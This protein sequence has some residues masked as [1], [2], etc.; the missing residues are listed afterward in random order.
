MADGYGLRPIKAQ[1]QASTLRFR[2]IA[3]KNGMPGP[4][5]SDGV[6]GEARVVLRPL[7]LLLWSLPALALDATTRLGKTWFALLLAVTASAIPAPGQSKQVQ[8]VR[9][10]VVTEEHLR[11]FRLPWPPA[12]VV[13]RKVI[14]DNQGFLWLGAADGLRRYDG[15]SFMRVPDDED[16]NGVGLINAESLMK[17]RTGA[18]WFGID[19]FLARYDPANGHLRRYRT[20]GG[21]SCD[22]GCDAHQITEDREGFVWLATNNGLIRL[23]PGTSRRTYYRHRPDD[24]ATIASD[25]VICTI[26]ARDGLLWVASSGALDAFDRHTGKVTRRIRFE[27]ESTGHLSLRG[28]PA[29]L[30]QDRSGMLWA[31]LSSGGD[32]VSID[33]N[34]EKITVYSFRVP[35]SKATTPAFVVSIAEDRTGAL[36][37][38]T[39]GLGL[40]KL[41]R[42]RDRVVWYESNPE[43]PNS[44]SADLVVGLFQDREGSFW[45]HTKGG[46]VLRF[47][48][49]PPVFRSYRHAPGNKNS[50]IDSAVISAYEDSK[51]ILWI[52]TERGLN[53]VDRRTGQ[54]KRYD[55]VEFTPGVRSIAEDRGGSL[56]FGTRGNGLVRFDRRTGAVRTFRHR[57]DDSRSLSNDYVAGLLVDRQ[58]IL[59]AAT[60]DGLNRYDEKKE[61][62]QSFKPDEKPT[63]YRS[64]AEDP[65]GA[66]WMASYEF[67][68][69]RFQ[70]STGEFT[71]FRSKPGDPAALSHDHVY[72]VYANKSG[73]VWAATFRGLD[74]FNPAAGNFTHY[75]ARNG[76]PTNTAL[77]VLEDEGGYLW[78]STPDGLARFDP[79]TA[80]SVDYHTSDGVPTDLF[81]TLAVAV[82]AGSGEMFF[83]SYSGL[84]AFFPKRVIDHSFVPPV[85]LTDLRLFGE[86]VPTGKGPLTEPI[87]SAKLLELPRDSIFSVDF[88]ALS[89]IDPARTRYRYKL[90]GLE[91]KWN[92]TDSN[93]RVAAYTTLPVGLY[94][95]QVRARTHR[96]D[97]TEGGAS[98]NIRIL[99]LWYDTWWF[100]SMLA[101]AVF[102][103]LWAAYRFRIGQL[104]RVRQLE[105][106]LAHINRVSM[107]G[108]L[109]ASIAH[110]VNQP[111]SGIVSNGSACLRWLARDPPNVEEV[112]EAV[113]DIVRDG[114]RAGE[115]I[116]RIRALTKWSGPPRE[117]LDLN[118]TVREVL[119]LVEDEAKRQRVV[120]RTLFADNLVPVSGDRVQLQQVMLN[121]ILN[122]LEA[123]SGIEDRPR[124]LIITT[125]NIDTDRVQVSVED[126][127]PGLDPNTANRIFEPF[128]T[129]KASGMGMGLSISRS[130]LQNHGGRLWATANEGRGAS[131]HFRLPK[132]QEEGA[133]AGVAGV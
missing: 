59:W 47:D 21:G 48:P 129:T 23:D 24:D 70:P 126:S 120:I 8:F 64:I 88:S 93:R 78:I 111:L 73:T 123:M 106:D 128:Y 97:W 86:L 16:R 40:L 50:L 125:W 133:H 131:F 51:R 10:P 112:R 7:A 127:G 118:D 66:L 92:E 46:D 80:T 2:S 99:P 89:Y 119:T 96:G 130:I 33:P 57:R 49:R 87:W 28:F 114:R 121:L 3:E 26:E 58:G 85:V 6:I 113:G 35:G 19:G 38:G 69:H 42:D 91:S 32:L 105:A 56:W 14:Q 25:T 84:I 30:Y 95:L 98:L 116:A 17:D 53:R 60:S 63:G 41:E 71:Q 132:Y 36:W 90:E 44:L 68:L 4:R 20:S 27:T 12:R 101:G 9:I 102:I 100:R 22:S 109:A 72:S 11:S 31:G 65:N 122:A 110:E 83:G 5:Q 52:G 15:Y 29:N 43:D 94:T 107:M 82:K 124:E 37:L 115:V 1:A 54:V 79:R 62:F 81:N 61:Q 45:A 74:K 18:F 55:N 77:G 108:E 76:L 75:N 13:A 34:T 117:K 103:L 104:E 67:G 39:T